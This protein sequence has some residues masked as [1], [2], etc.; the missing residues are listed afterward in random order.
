MACAVEAVPLVDED[1]WADDYE[2]PE[3][4]HWDDECPSLPGYGVLSVTLAEAVSRPT[5][6]P[7]LPEW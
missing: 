4:A 2:L 5:P 6:P 1:E 7:Q 3:D